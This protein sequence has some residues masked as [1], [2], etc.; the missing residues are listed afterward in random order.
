[1]L[2]GLAHVLLTR[3]NLPSGG[4][5]ARIRASEAWLRDRL[6]LFDRY[7]A[8]SVA[9]QTTPGVRWIIYLDPQS[10]AWLVDTMARYAGHGLCN[11][12]YRAEVPQ[13]ALRSDLR[14]VAPHAR[15]I[16]TTNLDNDDALAVDFSERVRQTTR[17]GERRALYFVNGLIKGPDGV[18]SRTD[19][20]NAF[21]SVV[22]PSE[23]P[24]TCWVDWHNRLGRHMPVTEVGGAPAW[25][26]VVHGA[27]VSNRVRG[28][29]I[30]PAPWAHLFPT[31]LDDVPP[32]SGRRLV[33]DRLV[34]VPLRSAR[35]GGRT[36]LRRVA[37]AALGKDGLQRLK[38]RVQ[39]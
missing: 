36:A 7:C 39:G 31:G 14:M 5:E 30:S 19:R 9:A 10:P 29:L 16:V 22:E 17:G 15:T 21:C 11:P 24:M 4:V 25:L 18:Y 37:V 13:S 3:F 27:N 23:S 6:D 34:R 33:Q 28:R 35:D 38:A 26:Q 32:P 20:V 1:M 2:D 12:I 8:P